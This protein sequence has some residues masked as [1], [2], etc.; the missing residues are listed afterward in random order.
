MAVDAALHAT[1][2]IAYGSQRG[3]M[4][5]NLRVDLIS[6]WVLGRFLR[7]VVG[8]YIAHLLI[9][10]RLGDGRHHSVLAHAGGIVLQGIVEIFIGLIRQTREHSCLITFAID[11]MALEA[12]SCLR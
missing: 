6:R 7:R 3:T 10:Q 5:E 2:C 1:S 9:A 11:S 4:L 8:G 12:R